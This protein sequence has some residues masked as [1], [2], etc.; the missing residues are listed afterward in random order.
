VAAGAA[1]V[2][3][4]VTAGSAAITNAVTAG[5]AAVTGTSSAATLTASSALQV[6]ASGAT[7]NA[8]ASSGQVK[9]T[10]QCA[11]LRPSTP[12]SL[13][14]SQEL[15][16]EG[17]WTAVEYSRQNGTSP[18]DLHYNNG[19][20]VHIHRSRSWYLP[21]PR[22][23]LKRERSRAGVHLPS[24]LL[25]LAIRDYQLAPTVAVRFLS[26][27]NRQTMQVHCAGEHGGQMTPRR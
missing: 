23:L 16:V 7:L 12:A 14:R 20:G 17:T 10:A 22:L 9:Q 4:A 11:F 5:S 6:G 13:R 19:T 1:T 18:G 3:N 15:D 25:N 8:S 2:T 26:G 27:T 21:L 24:R